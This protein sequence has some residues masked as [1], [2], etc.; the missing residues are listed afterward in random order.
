MKI[1]NGSRERA[2]QFQAGGGFGLEAA[3]YLVIGFVDPGAPPP[4]LQVDPWRRGGCWVA[5]HDV[6]TNFEAEVHRFPDLQP[7]AA[8]HA[9]MLA[10]FVRARVLEIRGFFI[11][12][13]AGVSR[14]AGCAA[15]LEEYFGQ[16]SARWF[17][18]C[19]PNQIVLR[20][21]RAAFGLPPHRP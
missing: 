16:D 1:V 15:A 3:P 12:C 18:R 13:E 4:L 21:L 7:F 5:C 14:S 20:E 17:T 10:G 11:H 6:D 2:E 19:H 9:A 8:H